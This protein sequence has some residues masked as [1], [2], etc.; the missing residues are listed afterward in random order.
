MREL[1]V[2]FLFYIPEG[3]AVALLGLTLLGIR[4]GRQKIVTIGILQGLAV[5]LIRNVYTLLNIK[6]GSHVIFTLLAMMLIFYLVTRI[7]WGL[8][9]AAA[10]ISFILIAVSEA[11]MYPL[12][13]SPLGLTVEKAAESMWWHVITAYLGDSLMFVTALVVGL[14]GFSFIKPKS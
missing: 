7:K 2:L 5:F 6:L 3:I 14:T 9:S 10:L 12:V 1:G 4:P 11:V 13:L 8:A